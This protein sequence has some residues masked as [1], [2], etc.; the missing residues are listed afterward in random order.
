MDDLWTPQP[1]DEVVV[2]G[3][4]F[5]DFEGVVESFNGETRKVRVRISFFG[6]DTPVELDPAQVRKIDAHDTSE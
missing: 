1:G 4:P 3:G 5:E 6:R 2:T